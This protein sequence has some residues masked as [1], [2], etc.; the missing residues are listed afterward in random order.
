M[1][2][3]HRIGDDTR[4]TTTLLPESRQSRAIAILA[5]VIDR[6][7][8][9]YRWTLHDPFFMPS[10]ALDDMPNF[11]RGIRNGAV[12][13]VSE[14]RDH[15][16]RPRGSSTVDLDLQEAATRLQATGGH[17]VWNPRVSLVPQSSAVIQYREAIRRLR[18]YNERLEQD[19]AVYERRAEA[20]QAFI[21]RLNADLR[22]A[23]AEIAD[24]I[25]RD[26]NRFFDS[27][28]DDIFYATKGRLYVLYLVL[29]EVGADYR[30][31]IEERRLTPAWRE[32]LASLEH[33]ARLDPLFVRNGRADSMLM[34]SHFAGQGFFMLRT[35]LQL[36]EISA[37]LR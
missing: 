16:A 10:S 33:A 14:V 11:Q 36:E 30:A 28:S 18:S 29:R 26:G 12:L 37:A 8:N 19:R 24:R 23:S 6:E 7:I 22:A 35:R 3:M 17:W 1:L 2:L 34:P 20:L 21:A 5:D 13:L 27:R 31:V 4:F 32:M 9:T 25:V 15:I